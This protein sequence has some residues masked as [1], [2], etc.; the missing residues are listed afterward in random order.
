[1]HVHTIVLQQMGDQ[2]YCIKPYLDFPQ[3]I[4]ALPIWILITTDDNYDK[5]NWK[6]VQNRLISDEDKDRPPHSPI[7]EENLLISE[8][9]TCLFQRLFLLLQNM[10]WPG[11]TSNLGQFA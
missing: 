6:Y 8:R 2:F 7:T 9:T 1:M 4:Y 3:K 5:L 11:R 10:K